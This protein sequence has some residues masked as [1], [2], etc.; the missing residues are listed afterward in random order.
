MLLDLLYKRRSVRQYQ[1]KPVEKEKINS[2]LEAA[3][4]SPSSRNRH[5]W[6]YIVIDEKNILQKLS[7]AKEHG[8]LFLK[9]APLAIAVAADPQICDVWIEDA[10]IASIIIQL[11]AESLD[12]ST[13]WIQIRE[14][15]NAQ[16]EWAEEIVKKELHLPDYFRVLSIIAI[17]YAA[18]NTI[19]HNKNDLLVSKAHDNNYLLKY[20]MTGEK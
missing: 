10:S 1:D 2:L 6:E 16:G 12:L 8:A 13:C 19:P 15:Q 5:P 14:R 4:L 11:T 20:Q 17:G 18:E 9:D 7:R 3:L